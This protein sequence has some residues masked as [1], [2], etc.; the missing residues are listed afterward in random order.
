M[1][2]KVLALG[3]A[4]IVVMV[5]GAACLFMGRVAIDM[6]LQ[7]QLRYAVVIPIAA[8]L[9]VRAMRLLAQIFMC[10]K[11]LKRS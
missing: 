7:G 6:L 8:F 2:K 3:F 9:A 5:S 11:E 10:T 4:T 1:L